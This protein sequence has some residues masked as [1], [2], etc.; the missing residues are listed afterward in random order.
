MWASWIEGQDCICDRR[1]KRLLL[2]NPPFP[3]HIF[4]ITVCSEGFQAHTKNMFPLKCLFYLPCVPPSL[5]YHSVL[6]VSVSVSVCA[7]LPV[8]LLLSLT[9]RLPKMY[10]NS[11]K[12]LNPPRGSLW[13]VF[14][15][16]NGDPTGTCWNKWQRQTLQASHQIRR[17]TQ[18]KA[19]RKLWRSTAPPQWYGNVA[20]GCHA[21]MTAAAHK[22]HRFV[23]GWQ[24]SCLKSYR[25]IHKW[26]GSAWFH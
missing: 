25:D 24:G 12:D 4:P 21:T 10:S 5:L 14:P 18:I 6:H 2:L 19:S 15:E 22:M 23:Y 11:V 9:P 7:T 13:S 3:L 8:S 26:H 17:W 1:T 16:S 20:F